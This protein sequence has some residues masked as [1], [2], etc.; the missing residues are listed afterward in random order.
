MKTLI[1][2]TLACDARTTD[3][4]DNVKAV[5]HMKTGIPTDQ[6]CIAFKGK[7]VENSKRLSEYSIQSGCTVH[8]LSL[9]RSA[10]FRWGAENLRD[11][12]ED[13]GFLLDGL[14]DN[15]LLQ[16]LVR[17]GSSCKYVY[18]K[19][20][21]SA[22]RLVKSEMKGVHLNKPVL[23]SHRQMPYWVQQKVALSPYCLALGFKSHWQDQT[24]PVRFAVDS[25]GPVFLEF[26]LIAAKAPN[27]T[28]TLGLVDAA[29]LLGLEE[30]L[31]SDLSR[32]G[33]KP[34]S[35]A[36]ALSPGS[37]Y[38]FANI[39]G[40]GPAKLHDPGTNPNASIN[41][42]PA[43]SYRAALN[44]EAMG[45]EDS[46]W[47]M[48]IQ[49]GFLLKDGKLSFYRMAEDGHW[50]SSGILSWCLPEKVVPCMFMKS[51]IGYAQMWFVKI[52]DCPPVVCPGCDR[53][54]RKSVV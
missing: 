1:G 29:S 23:L 31:P 28:P 30:G 18:S 53:R 13:L 47:N 4:H 25:K 2:K 45:N 42:L 7:T 19:T 21:L 15:L 43:G 36:I 10:L 40:V 32:P 3:I 14:V 52:W 20:T 37:G 34:K 26:Q 27:G 33:G 12:L 8:Q 41:S 50:H 39:D 22:D 51:F 54:D 49:A 5:V 44:W 46:K 16:D 6:Q 48:P 9:H 38:V 11:L 17:F 35:F 24:R